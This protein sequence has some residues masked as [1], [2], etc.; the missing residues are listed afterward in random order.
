MIYTFQADTDMDDQVEMHVDITVAMPCASLSGVD[1]TDDTNQ[2]VFSYGTLQR[3]DTWWHLNAEQRA[4]FE[5]MAHINTFLREEYHSVADLLFKDLMRT[6]KKT[7]HKTTSM[8]TPLTE[9]EKH[10]AC[11]LHG[12]LGINKV[13]GVLHLVG[14]AQPVMGLFGDHFV[15]EFRRVPA[16]FTHRINRLSF[17]HHAASSSLVSAL[18]GDETLV[19]DEETTVQY[20]LNI[21]PT[22]IHNMFSTINTYQYSVTENIR[23]LGEFRKE[24][25]LRF[26]YEYFVFL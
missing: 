20:F 23:K 1:L 12:T 19:P 7:L 21:V 17:G 9:G 16:N 11:R 24:I 6:D 10:D 4:Q 3:E 8:G 14:G 13:A 25:E 5:Q 18:E 26:L 15:F 2:E 22:E